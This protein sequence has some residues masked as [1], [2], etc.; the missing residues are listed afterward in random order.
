MRD[1]RTRCLLVAA[2]SAALF[3]ASGERGARAEADA[4]ARER[5]AVR[6]SITL[7]GQSPDAELLAATDPKAQVS[8]LLES[9]A[10]IDRFASFV[11]A[12]MNDEPDPISSREPA[13]WLTREVLAKGRP[14]SDLFVGGYDVEIPAGGNSVADPAV[15]PNPD[16]LG[17]FR[18][19]PWLR[20]YA[21]NEVAGLKIS[22]AYRIMNNVIGLEL[23]PVTTAEGADISATGRAAAACRGCHFEG[24]FALD[25]VA[26]V[27]TRRR[28]DKFGFL[29]SPD[30]PQTLLD[31]TTIA[32]DKELV[33]ALVASENFSF[34]ACRLA[35][36]FLYSR[37]ELTCE[38]T[39]FDLC[40]D[41]FK[42]EKTMQSALRAV[43]G[44]ASFCQ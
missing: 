8:R 32:N 26:R 3:A 4:E 1:L 22:T 11:N 20:R 23:N 30:P 34:R 43:I 38:A 12:K 44:D 6:M 29:P 42:S 18:S 24:P 2:A 15:T 37:P 33:T 16:G 35:F 21:G 27:L 19:A 41:R 40:V 9:Q 13:Y 39:L 31:G 10:F 17:Y 36:E 25:K 7:T 28:L 5:C 14:W